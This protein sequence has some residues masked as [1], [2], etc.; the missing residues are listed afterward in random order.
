MG[1]DEVHGGLVVLAEGGKGLPFAC[2]F[3]VPILFGSL[4]Q[5]FNSSYACQVIFLQLRLQ[6]GEGERGG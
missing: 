1:I 6:G 5:E 3:W 2:S 4:E